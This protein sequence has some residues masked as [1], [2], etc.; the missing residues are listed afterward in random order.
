ME[1][2]Y[3]I[4]AITAGCLEMKTIFKYLYNKNKIEIEKDNPGLSKREINRM[5]SHCAKIE[6]ASTI[7]IIKRHFL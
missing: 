3:R 2:I 5:A 1:V 4:K 7:A 6:F